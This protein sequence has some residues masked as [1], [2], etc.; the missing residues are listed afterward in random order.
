MPASAFVLRVALPVPLPRLFDYLPPAGE[1]VD[2]GWV[3]CRVRVPFGP[4]ELVG[5]VAGVGAADPSAPDPKPALA[6]LDF[7]PLFEGELLRSLHWLAGYVHAPSGRRYS[8]SRTSPST[9]SDARSTPSQPVLTQ[10]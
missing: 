6:R 7:E 9:T 4:R 2:G 5:V 8:R 3:G 1:A 10:T